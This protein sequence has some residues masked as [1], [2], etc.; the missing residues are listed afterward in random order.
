MK[1]QMVTLK[2]GLRLILVDTNTF[3]T[4]TTLLLVGAGSRYERREN[5]GIA[6][7]LE[8]MFYKGSKKYPNPEI[9]SQTIEGMGGLWNAFT[10]KDYTGYYIKAATDHFPQMMDILSDLLLNSLFQEE[11]I[12]KEKGVIVEEINMYEDMPQRKIGDIFERVMYD[13][14]PLGME[15]AGSKETVT[16]FSRK[17]FIDYMSSLYYPNNAVLIVA[18]GL[19]RTKNLQAKIENYRDI[20]EQ[21]LGDWK[22]GE[23]AGFVHWDQ[24]FSRPRI[25]VHQ[26]KTEQAH[27]CLGFPTF[28]VDDRRR[29]ALK[30]LATVLGGG[31][32]SR[33][34][35]EV[36]E[37]RGLCYYIGTGVEQYQEIGSIVTQAGV[38]KDPVKVRDAVEAVLEEHRK[39]AAGK[40]A[41]TDIARS[42][43]MLKGRLLL[44]MEDSFNIAH[45]YGLKQLHENKIESP[46]ERIAAI[47]A[48]TKAEIVVLAKELF[49]K[50]KLNFAIIGP[51]PEGDIHLNL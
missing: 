30:V 5:N 44:S 29:P 27:F 13:G 36:R 16:G 40:V 37:K 28:A 1:P 4:L 51:F 31:A 41:E 50:S 24:A 18:G 32:S 49:T 46:Q 23:A 15:I 47:E 38:A 42:K 35:Q 8:H 21:K 11:E 33:L 43:E 20:V 2:N 14:N 22:A 19:N 9:I 10:S 25:H 7:F 34:F 3:P 26:K 6:H 12:A 17:T 48:V 39:I 45:F